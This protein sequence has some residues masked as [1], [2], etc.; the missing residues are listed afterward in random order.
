MNNSPSGTIHRKLSQGSAITGAVLSICWLTTLFL[1]LP[2]PSNATPAEDLNARLIPTAEHINAAPDVTLA[3]FFRHYRPEVKITP[4]A[5]ESIDEMIETAMTLLPPDQYTDEERDT[6]REEYRQTIRAEFVKEILREFVMVYTTDASFD[7]TTLVDENGTPLWH[8]FLDE[9]SQDIA[10]TPYVFSA[11]EP[12]LWEPIAEAGKRADHLSGKRFR[13]EPFFWKPFILDRR[14]AETEVSI[15]PGIPNTDTQVTY[16]L[17]PMNTFP[18]GEISLLNYEGFWVVT[19]AI[20]VTEQ[21][22]EE[23]RFTDY[24]MVDGLPVPETI[25][26]HN[27][28]APDAS[29]NHAVHLTTLNEVTY[30]LLNPSTHE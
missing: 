16:V 8:P 6:F 10:V 19:S 27:R 11:K 29:V 25:S 4:A 1:F 20:M 15:H 13:S 17:E 5:E 24:T 21:I 26:I 23:Y 12:L 14:I 7:E 2:I 9:A 22:E 30:T 28:Y 18:R 3:Y